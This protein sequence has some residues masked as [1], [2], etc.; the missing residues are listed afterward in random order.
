MR[1][2]DVGIVWGLGYMNWGC[3]CR[4]GAQVHETKLLASFEGWVRQSEVFCVVWGLGY[5]SFGCLYRQG[6]WLHEM[7]PLASFEGWVR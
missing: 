4:Q 5:M 6:A 7:K 3:L 2:R 1:N